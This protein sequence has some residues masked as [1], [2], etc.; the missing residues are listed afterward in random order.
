MNTKMKKRHEQ[1]ARRRG[2]C[3]S[4]ASCLRLF[5]GD[6]GPGKVRSFRN[7]GQNTIIYGEIIIQ[8]SP[9]KSGPGKAASVWLYSAS[10]VDEDTGKGKLAQKVALKHGS[11]D[12]EIESNYGGKALR[13]EV[14]FVVEA[15]F[16]KPGALVVKNEHKHEFFLQNASLQGEKHQIV[17]FEINSWIYPFHLTKQDRVFFP[18]TCYLPNQTPAA[19]VELR[20][21]ELERLRGDGRGERRQWDQIYD[22]AYYN[23]LGIPERSPEYRRPVLGGSPSFPYPRRLRTGRPSNN[24]DTRVEKRLRGWFNM[25][26]Y[27]PPDERFSQQKFSEFTTNAIRA[28]LHFVMPEAGAIFKQETSHFESFDQIHRLFVSNRDRTL[29]EWMVKRLKQDL[30]DELFK[31]V[32]KVVKERPVEFPLPRI[33]AG[34]QFAWM[35]DDEFGRQMLAGTNPTLISCLQNFPPQGSNGVTSSIKHSEIEHNLDGLTLAEAMNQWRLFKLDHHDYLLPFLGRINSKEGICAY[36]SRTLL[37]LKDDCTLKPLAI[38]LSLPGSSSHEEIS[39]VFCPAHDGTKAALWQ[40]AKAHVAAAD[41]VY[42][43][44]VSHWLNT[45]AVVEPFIIATRRKLSVMHPIH[46]LL[47][48]HFK[49]TMQVNALARSMLLNAGGILENML[50]TRDISMELSSFLY[51]SWRFDEQSLPADLIKRG[52]ATY[53][54]N[55]PENVELLFQDYPYGADG[56]DIWIAI[57]NWVTEYCLY[58]YEDD[59]SLRSDTEITEW[60]SEIRNVGHGDKSNETWWYAMTTLSELIETL[61]ILI[62]TVSAHHAAIS[63]GQYDYAGYPPNRPTACRKPIPSEGTMEFAEFLTDPDKYFLSMLPGKFETTLGI[64]VVDVLS[65]RSSGETSLGQQPSMKW[66][67]DERLHRIF[68]GFEDDLEEV[69]ERIQARNRDPRLKNRRGKANFRYELLC[70]DTSEVSSSAGGLK[71]G[72]PNSISI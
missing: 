29:D 48:P 59:A 51:R 55:Q 18:N 20:K 10:N 21:D 3:S 2:F 72:I 39:R 46:R 40:L 44:L 5:Q 67:D 14:E 60:W 27:V 49:D 9:G 62:W 15:D 12:D 38:E 13:Y 1:R 68:I 47:E 26:I 33:A 53:N 19:V 71:G 43:H 66:T 30:P 61:T 6:V 57:K 8:V 69:K 4:L 7:P 37:F 28:A 50:F 32:K 63:L 22:Y 31:K 17:H 70:P 23:D 11:I 24:Y 52:L 56:L 25:D 42:H 54:P 41:S 58:F 16:G 65:R 64:A 34:S 35:D 45:H 36:A